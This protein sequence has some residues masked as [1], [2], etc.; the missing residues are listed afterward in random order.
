[1]EAIEEVESKAILAVQASRILAQSNTSVKNAALSAIATGLMS[2]AT[3]ILQE[4]AKD[5]C[6]AR[7]NG[8]AEAMV[9]RLTITPKRIVAMCEGLADLEALP[10]PVGQVLGGGT[11][12]NGLQITRLRVPLG[13]VGVIFES[14]PNVSVDAAA[15]CLKA[16]NAAILR[17]GSEAIRSN[18]ALARVMQDAI[19]S[20]GLP[21]A[22]VQLIESTDRAAARRLM[23]MKGYVDCLIPRGGP[24]LIKT[25]VESSTVPV[26]ET[27]TGN[28]HVYVDSGAD[29]KKAV[30]IIL[31][32]KTKRPSVCNAA[33]TLLIHRDV[34]AT[35]LPM[36]GDALDLAGVEI[37]GDEDVRRTL[38]GAKIASESDWHE[39]YSALIL[40]VKV[41]KDLDEAIGHITKYGTKHSEAI[42][43][44]NY[45]SS[46]AFTERVD[47]AAV[48][49]NASTHFTDG[50]QFG[51][52][53]EIGISNQKL[54]ARGPMGLEQLTTYKYIIRGEGQ[55]RE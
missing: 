42:V 3:D 55:I 1:M 35:F 4:N 14:R 21:R 31:N 16:G 38:T 33:E 46:Q 43:T 48:Y 47:A 7:E 45:S 5:V 12:P 50:Y 49:V 13:V 20:V 10:D 37:R 41:V 17:G 24:S 9:D 15:I 30:A 26:V 32:A 25:V 11:R 54:H 6:A 53:A 19:E 22:A 28:C 27:G 39:E 34:A 18:I 8:L 52:G 2:H 40:A 29:L 51:M 23:T 44:E 36:I